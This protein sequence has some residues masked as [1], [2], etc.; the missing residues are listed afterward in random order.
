MSGTVA[1]IRREMNGVKDLRSI[2]RTMKSVSASR[3]GQYETAVQAL[4]DY[5]KSVEL[6]VA[7]C[8]REKNDAYTFIDEKRVSGVV[9]AV[10]F[11]SDQGLAGPFN[12]NICDFAKKTLSDIPGHCRVWAVGERV[13]EEWI[14]S[15]IPVTASFV[16]PVSFKGIV[17]LVG[18]I[19]EQK[20]DRRALDTVSGLY[21]FYNRPQMNEGYTPIVQKLLPFDRQWLKT[22]AGRPWPSTRYVQIVGNTDMTLRALLREYLFV[23]LFR[24]CAESLASENASRLAAMERADQNIDERLNE[25][26][27]RFHLLR[28]EKIDEE[29]FDVIAGFDS[30]L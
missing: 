4:A 30:I 3:A 28:K 2:V 21:L 8:L 17:P 6:G 19:L 14:N 11:G 9:V 22:M 12:S 13:G 16:L 24:A 29:L 7:V 20:E 26:Y 25:L 10:V 1:S 27:T 5:H 23:S 15:T 18:G